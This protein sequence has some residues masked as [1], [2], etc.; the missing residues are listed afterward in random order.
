M[1]GLEGQI[2]HTLEKWRNG[3]RRGNSR[4]A[5]SGSGNLL[6]QKSPALSVGL[7]GN[8]HRRRRVCSAL[9]ST[10]RAFLDI[11]FLLWELSLNK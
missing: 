6:W 1:L 4:Q 7:D 3:L 5:Y 11:S 2:G 9:L 10:E 8:V